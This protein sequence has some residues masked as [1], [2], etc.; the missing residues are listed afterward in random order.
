MQG[1]RSPS[2]LLRPRRRRR[3]RSPSTPSRRGS[4]SMPGGRRPQAPSARRPRWWPGRRAASTVGYPQP[5]Y[6]TSF[7][8]RFAFWPTSTSAP[9]FP[10]TLS[11]PRPSQAASLASSPRQETY[12]PSLFSPLLKRERIPETGEK[13]RYSSWTF[14]LPLSPSFCSFSLS[15]PLRSLFHGIS[16]SLP[17]AAHR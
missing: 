7:T 17:A 8:P 10:E 9:P 6:V 3:R 1:R 4:N 13:E 11:R 5:Y 16:V 2:V 12:S 15:N 14:P